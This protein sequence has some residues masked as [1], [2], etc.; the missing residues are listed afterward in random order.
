[1]SGFDLILCEMQLPEPRLGPETLFHPRALAGV[2]SEVYIITADGRL[3]GPYADVPLPVTDAGD[4]VSKFR[5]TA[6]PM[7]TAAKAARLPSTA[8]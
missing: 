7:A 3:F 5:P 2:F 6:L 8:T 4:D 1:M